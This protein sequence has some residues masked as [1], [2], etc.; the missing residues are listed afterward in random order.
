MLCL[1]NPTGACRASML[2]IQ[3]C[4]QPLYHYFRSQYPEY[5]TKE[6]TILLSNMACLSIILSG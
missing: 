3:P 1:R 6:S 4:P 2:I 5:P